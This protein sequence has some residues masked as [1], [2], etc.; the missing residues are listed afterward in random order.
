MLCKPQ[1]S[2]KDSPRE[3]CASVTEKVPSMENPRGDRK[4]EA[5]V[6]ESVRLQ[7][8]PEKEELSH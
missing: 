5:G 8:G 3:G 4:E 2:L 7:L 6:W 1:A